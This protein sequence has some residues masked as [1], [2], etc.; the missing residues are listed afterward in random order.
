MTSAEPSSIKRVRRVKTLRTRKTT[1]RTLIMKKTA[2][3]RRMA[4]VVVVAILSMRVKRRKRSAR[5]VARVGECQLSPLFS[6][7]RHEGERRGGVG[8][9]ENGPGGGWATVVRNE[10]HGWFASVRMDSN[11]HQKQLV[12]QAVTTWTA[13]EESNSCWCGDA[14][15]R[16]L[17]DKNIKVVNNNSSLNKN[18]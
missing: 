17:G 18:G 10:E 3:P 14:I 7:E 11:V 6:V 8:W 16:E 13:E 9:M 12:Q 5:S 1:M 2:K 4:V 15:D